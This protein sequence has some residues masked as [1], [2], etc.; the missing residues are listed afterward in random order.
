MLRHC[1]MFRWSEDAT[2][3]AKAAIRRGLADMAELECV[4]TFV[5][6]PDAGLVDG[7]WDYVVNAE[8]ETAADY[9]TYA[10]DP[11]HLALIAD[12]IRPAISARAAVQFEV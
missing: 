9:L 5:H 10:E 8:F 6:G 3:D 11:D 4:A 12:V 7:N 1:V 2:D